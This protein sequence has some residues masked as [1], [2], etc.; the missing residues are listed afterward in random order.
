VEVV[1]RP[2]PTAATQALELVSASEHARGH[3]TKT[4][5]AVVA[6]LRSGTG[7]G[8]GNEDEELRLAIRH[9]VDQSESD[10]RDCSWRLGIGGAR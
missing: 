8:V 7:K 5:H 9:V 2:E 3:N 1:A 6:Y 4:G 10:A